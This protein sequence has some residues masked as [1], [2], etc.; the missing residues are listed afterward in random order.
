MLLGLARPLTLVVDCA[1]QLLVQTG[2]VGTIAEARQAAADCLASGAPRRKWDEMLLAQGADL[3]LF[4]RKLAIE[5]TA[6]VV[7]ELNAPEAGFVSRCDGRL[8]GQAIRE[9]G[10]GRLTRESAIDYR[11][12][13]D[14][15]VK[16]GETVGKGMVIARVHAGDADLGASARAVIASA[17]EFSEQL[18]G[19]PPLIQEVVS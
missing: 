8:V 5:H 4:N 14:S 3:E 9:L 6:P 16:P 15:L 7:L 2:K 12:G 13:V 11:V 1:A 18:P 10:G 19:Q 17:F